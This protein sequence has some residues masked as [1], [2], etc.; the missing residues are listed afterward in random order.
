MKLFVSADNVCLM[1]DLSTALD[2]LQGA[3]P[4]LIMQTCFEVPLSMMLIRL[5]LKSTVR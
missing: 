4:V 1:R 3:P 5:K 2:G